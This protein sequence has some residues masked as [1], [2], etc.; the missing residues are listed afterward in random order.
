MRELTSFVGIVMQLG[1]ALLLVGLF[2]FL[3]RENRRRSY[4]TAWGWAWA[5]IESADRDMY[6]EKRQ[7]KAN[8]APVPASPPIPKTLRRFP[9]AHPGPELQRE[10]YREP[11][12]RALK[13]IP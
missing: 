7:R 10:P 4:F 12:D 11:L 8:G 6:L 5:A 13:G 9:E 1:A 3:R 2:Y